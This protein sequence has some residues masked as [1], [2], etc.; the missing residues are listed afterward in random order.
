MLDPK[1]LNQITERG[2][3]ELQIT[4]QLDNFKTG[5]P[6]LNIN[7]AATPSAGIKVLTKEEILSAVKSSDS[8]EGAR[9]K[10]VPASGAAT[11]M[12]KDLYE[13]AKSLKKG[14]ALKESSG[15]YAFY[16]NFS[17]FPFASPLNLIE[18]TL[19]KTALDLGE[20]PKGLIPFHKYENCVRT[21]FEEHLVEGA[22]YAIDSNRDVNIVFTVSAEHINDFVSL[23]EKVKHKYEAD[24]NCKFNVIFTTQQKS[25]DIIAVDMNNKPFLT[26]DGLFMFRPGG[27]GALLANLNDIDS[28]IIIIKNIDNVVKESLISDTVIWK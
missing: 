28:D 2:I 27:H 17:K 13:G 6:Y 10:F 9:V 26:E 12:F 3:N 15:A 19:G 1:Q 14:E 4:T 8:F 24:Y 20:K 18:L 5:F 22:L 11:R 16:K 25:T 21:P 23:F 7:T